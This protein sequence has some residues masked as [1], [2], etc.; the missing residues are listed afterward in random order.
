MKQVSV[1]LIILFTALSVQAQQPVSSSAV[2]ISVYGNKNLRVS[3]DGKEYNLFNTIISGSKSTLTINNLEMGQH[4]LLFTRTDQPSNRTGRISTTFNLRYKFDMLIKLNGNGSLELIETLKPRMVDNPVP[5]SAADFTILLRNVRN[6]R[7]VT[8]RRTIIA[9]A[10]NVTNN[11]FTSNQVV[12]LLQLVNAENYRLELAKLSYRSVTD[13]SNFNQLYYLLNSQSSRNE[14]EDYV[15]NYQDDYDQDVPD[16]A[17]SDANFNNLY[18]SIQ[19]QWPVST[20]MNSLTNA[21][22][23]T[24]NYFSTY[25]ASRLIQLVNAENNRLQ[26]AKLSYRAIID[27]NNFNQIYNLLSSQSSKNELTAYVNNYRDG[28]NQDL[29]MS[30]A[31]FNNLYQSIQQQWPVSTQMNSLTN[32]F[33]ATNNY[34]STYQASRL[35]QLVNAENNRLQLA[36]LSYRTITD[37]YNFNQIYNLFNSQA[38]KNELAA[39]VNN[40]Q[41]DVNQNVVMSDANFNNLYQSI[42]QQWPVSTQMNSLTNAFNA[43]NNYFSTYQASRLIQLVNAE[44]N[45]LQLAKLS[46]RVILDRNNFNQIYNLLS[47]QVSKNELATYINTNYNTGSSPHVAMSDAEFTVLFQT[48]ERQYLPFEQMNSLTEVFNNTRNYFTT[49]QVKRLIPLVSLES[50]RIQLA[51]LSYRTI[52]DRANFSQLYDLIES[53]AGRNE[54]DAYVNAYQE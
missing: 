27:R 40:Y 36:K 10:F 47:S 1:Y 3:V 41:E 52:I 45:R 53:Q 44:S 24:N 28:D 37:R 51:K 8:A 4:T 17:M 6:Q 54:L 43:T 14:L 12:Q 2:T 49:A 46:Y 13:R 34:F 33:N 31:N 16:E 42:Q 26:L 9:N 29:A 21:F 35:I 19:Q 32:A 7:S 18:Q 11:Y 20:Q 38:S 5:M 25:Q 48:I 23:A 22:N 30:D 15:N 39:Y 50:N